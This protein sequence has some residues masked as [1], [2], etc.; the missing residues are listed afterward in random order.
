MQETEKGGIAVYPYV[1][2][3]GAMTSSFRA[4]AMRLIDRR[5]G[6]RYRIVREGE[7]KGR[8]RVSTVVPGAEE[9]VRDHRWGV[10]FEC[11]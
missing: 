9:I 5:C 2:E 8:D 6:G 1:P 10:Q 7:T 4:E 11:R 3:R